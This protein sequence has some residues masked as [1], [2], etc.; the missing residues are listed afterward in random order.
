VYLL[1]EAFL[2][3]QPGD[4]FFQGI[5]NLIDEVRGDQVIEAAIKQLIDLSIHE[6][7]DRFGSLVAFQH[8]GNVL[9]QAILKRRYG[10]E[11]W[12]ARL[13]RQCLNE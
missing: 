8:R 2:I 3:Y 12:G 13:C 9:R 1:F 4:K 6:V 10:I 11:D 7:T 5:E